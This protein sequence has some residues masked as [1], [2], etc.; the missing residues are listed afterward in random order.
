MGRTWTNHRGVLWSRDLLS[1]NHDA[2]QSCATLQWGHC[3]VFS[4]S[5]TTWPTFMLL[6]A[7]C[8]YN[9]DNWIKTISNSPTNTGIFE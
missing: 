1:T 2:G 7:V 3:S 6:N 5:H 8:S 4:P 9:F